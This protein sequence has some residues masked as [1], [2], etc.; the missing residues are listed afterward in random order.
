MRVID[1]DDVWAIYR[2][3][4]GLCRHMALLTQGNALGTERVQ[5]N[6][7]LQGR[8]RV[9]YRWHNRWRES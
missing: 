4:S 3:P 5:Q 7:A 6:Q 9:I 2:A 8:N 1:A